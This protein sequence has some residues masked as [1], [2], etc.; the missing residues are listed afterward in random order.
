MALYTSRSKCRQPRPKE[1]SVEMIRFRSQRPPRSI[2]AG[3][4]EGQLLVE[5]QP[6]RE[7]EKSPLI[8]WA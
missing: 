1:Y 8:Y 4:C 2:V 7:W 5:G 3:V 6:S